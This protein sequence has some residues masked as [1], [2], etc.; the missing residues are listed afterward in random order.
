MP[1]GSPAPILEIQNLEVSYGAVQ[2]LWGFSLSV[3][4]G[5]VVCIIGPNGAGK[6][7][8]LNT[9]IGVLKPTRGRILFEGQDIA[10]LPPHQRVARHIALIPEGRQLWPGMSVED[11]L[12]MG[13]FPPA[14]RSRVSHNLEGVYG[15]FPR[16]K[17]RRHQLAGTLSGGEQQMCAI[18]RGLMAEPHLL[19]LDEPSL[20]LAP[21]LVDEIFKFVG[22]IVKHG[23]TILLVAQNIDY[24]LQVSDYGYVMETGHIVLQG[25]SDMLLNNK[26]VQEAYLGGSAEESGAQPESQPAQG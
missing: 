21:I 3:T 22:E 24:A 18:G 20:G 14:F 10:S 11:T 8:T 4:K 17:E 1:E 5:Q 25:S 19:L 26:H 2:V 16:L 7:T 15:M 23:V 9:I 13:A 12:K 6:T